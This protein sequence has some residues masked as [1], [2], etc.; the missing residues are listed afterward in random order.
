MPKPI[1]VGVDPL[2]P[3]QSP[4]ALGA[5]LGRFSLVRRLWWSSAISTTR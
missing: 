1:I 2:A 5:A 4:V 3:D